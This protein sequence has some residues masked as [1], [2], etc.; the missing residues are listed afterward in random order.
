MDEGRQHPFY[1]WLVRELAKRGEQGKD[2]TSLA[3]LGRAADIDDST[4]DGWRRGEIDPTLDTVRSVARALGLETIRLLVIAQLLT[5]EEADQW[6]ARSSLD[7]PSVL[8]D[9]ELIQAIGDYARELTRRRTP[10]A[11][12]SGNGREPF[13]PVTWIFKDTDDD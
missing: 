11:P 6:E 12:A 13:K 9:D 2:V 5:E 1:R 3:D 10:R 4:F 7:H 8:S